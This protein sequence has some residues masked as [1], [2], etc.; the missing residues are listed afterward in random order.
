[1]LRKDLFGCTAQSFSRHDVDDIIKRFRAIV[2]HCVKLY[3]FLLWIYFIMFEFWY[4]Y[5]KS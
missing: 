5:I 2:K 3:L 4:P 1:M